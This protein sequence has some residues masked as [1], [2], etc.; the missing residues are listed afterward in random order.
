MKASKLGPTSDLAIAPTA[1]ESKTQPQEVERTRITCATVPKTLPMAI[2]FNRPSESDIQP[3]RIC[4]T[5][6]ARL[7]RVKNRPIWPTVAP[8]SFK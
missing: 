6:G 3:P 8:S 5:S 2:A 4:N 7:A 1:L